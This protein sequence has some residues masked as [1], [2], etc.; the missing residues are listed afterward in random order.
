MHENLLQTQ[1]LKRLLQTQGAKAPTIA[2]LVTSF[3]LELLSLKG[4]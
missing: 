4:D 3:V 1:A 2:S